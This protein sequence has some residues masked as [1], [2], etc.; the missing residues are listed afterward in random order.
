MT[1]G[2]ISWDRDVIAFDDSAVGGPHS[3][4]HQLLGLTHAV[5]IHVIGI[6]G[7]LV[8]ARL[9]RGTVGVHGTGC[10]FGRVY[11]PRGGWIIGIRV[12]SMGN[13]AAVGWG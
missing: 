3:A 8:L 10:C 13:Y 7:L 2:R 12:P 9:A 6:G 11:R 5:R 4:N 1:E